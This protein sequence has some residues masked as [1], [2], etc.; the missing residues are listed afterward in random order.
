MTVHEGKVVII[1][2]Q[3]LILDLNADS[4]AIHV[5]DTDIPATPE[6]SEQLGAPARQP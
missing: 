6:A 5:N 4:A 1:N 3:M 2:E